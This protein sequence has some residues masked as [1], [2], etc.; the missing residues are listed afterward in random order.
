M[1]LLAN[2]FNPLVETLVFQDCLA[3]TNISQTGQFTA[4]Q[5]QNGTL[6]LAKV[7]T[8]DVFYNSLMYSAY[9]R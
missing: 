4:T 6:Y 3:V 2:F 1:Q 9:V 5:L 7:V 8:S